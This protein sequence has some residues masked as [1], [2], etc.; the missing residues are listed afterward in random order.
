[1]ES[2]SEQK[3]LHEISGIKI[4]PL[5]EA[6]ME[7]LNM[8]GLLFSFIEYNNLISLKSL[9]KIDQVYFEK[10][11]RMDKK[12]LLFKDTLVIVEE[13]AF[14]EGSSNKIYNLN[15]ENIVLRVGEGNFI[16]YLLENYLHIVLFSYQQII[17]NTRIF[18]NIYQLVY[19]KDEL[20]MM[21][22]MEKFDGTLYDLF[23][24]RYFSDEYFFK[25]VLFQIACTLKLLQDKIKFNHNDLKLDNIFYKKK[26]EGDISKDNISLV[27]GDLGLSRFE[28]DTIEFSNN[29]KVLRDNNRNNKFIKGGDILYFFL[30]LIDLINKLGIEKY[31]QENEIVNKYFDYFKLEGFDYNNMTPI[32]QVVGETKDEDYQRGFYPESIIEK[33]LDLGEDKSECIELVDYEEYFKRKYLKYKR[34]YLLIKQKL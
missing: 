4:T 32:E 24:Q 15:I 23:L 30:Q 7:S 13:E 9:K 17:F 25:K 19:D 29:L 33:L 28:I 16:K 10:I 31:P 18:P 34:K 8:L 11:L 3:K 2:S 21:C 6:I 26:V 12:N 5:L 1:M 27:L 14:A 22:F 20:S